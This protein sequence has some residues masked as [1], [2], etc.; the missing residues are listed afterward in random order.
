MIDKMIDNME[1]LREV[2][3]KLIQETVDNPSGV[4]KG[5]S[6]EMLITRKTFEE[7]KELVE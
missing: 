5:Q 1:N 2:L 3:L 4:P 7:L 6:I